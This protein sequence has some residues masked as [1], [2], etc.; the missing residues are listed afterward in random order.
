[1]AREEH[2]FHGTTEHLRPGAK[3]L[4]VG[5]LRGKTPTF[6]HDT[7]RE[8]AYATSEEANAWNYAEKAWHST[9]RGIPRVYEVAPLGDHEPDP[10]HDERGRSRGNYETDRRSRVGWKVISERQMPEHMGSPEDWK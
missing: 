3:V 10:T 7:S 1:M 5:Q 2:F 8:H 9:D 6:P 4:P